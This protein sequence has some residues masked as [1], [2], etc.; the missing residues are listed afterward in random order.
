M[1]SIDV[2]RLVEDSGR[3][4]L[5][6]RRAPKVPTLI[7]IDNGASDEFSVI[8]IYTQDRIGVLFAITHAIH[9]LGL[10][11]H[12]AKIS[13]NVDQVADV[14][15]VTDGEGRKIHEKERL[16]IIRDTLYQ[17]LVMEHEERIAQLSH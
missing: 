5:F 10:S 15:Y 1:G 12:L 4:S 7:Q 11:I 6:R 14:F 16:E 8:E 2:A 13:T 3:P 9:Q 17:R